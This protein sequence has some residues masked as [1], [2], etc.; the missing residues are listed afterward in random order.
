MEEKEAREICLLRHCYRDRIGAPISF[1]DIVYEDSFD[2]AVEEAEAYV[3]ILNFENENVS[4]LIL[5]RDSPYSW[6]WSCMA[7]VHWV[8]VVRIKL[9][10]FVN[11]ER[12]AR[13]AYSRR[14]AKAVENERR[15]LEMRVVKRRQVNNLERKRKRKLKKKELAEAARAMRAAISNKK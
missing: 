10:S 9:G 3:R 15:S 8:E 1:D 12:Y 7:S 5:R 14:M 6:R 13:M 4:N 11:R 2:E